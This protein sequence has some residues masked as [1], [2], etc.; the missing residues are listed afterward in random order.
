VKHNSTDEQ[1]VNGF[2]ETGVL[3]ALLRGRFRW[4]SG[5]GVAW[6]DCVESQL[7][8]IRLQKTLCR[9]DK[10][11]GRDAPAFLLKNQQKRLH[12]QDTL[13]CQSQSSKDIGSSK[14]AFDERRTCDGPSSKTASNHDHDC[15]EH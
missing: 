2:I 13:S 5:L 1:I 12:M 14:G 4:L 7:S 15:G 3:V 6:R 8:L 11:H 9:D 10:A